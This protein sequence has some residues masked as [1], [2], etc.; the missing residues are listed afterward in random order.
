MAGGLN[1]NK[2]EDE[3]RKN[4]LVILDADDIKRAQKIALILFQP[5]VEHVLK[6]PPP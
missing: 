1:K 6:N 3:M 4:L 2:N 5:E